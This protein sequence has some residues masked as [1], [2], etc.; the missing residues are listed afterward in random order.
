M[1]KLFKVY[2]PFTVNEIKVNLA[3]PA[4]FYLFILCTMFG[5]FINY[6]LW[7]AIYG[8]ASGATLGGLTRGEM[9]VYVFMSYVTSSLTMIS[10]SENVSEDVVKG[11]VSMN[12]I[13]PIDYRLSL[14]FMA[15][16]NVIYRFFAPCILVWVGLEYYKVVFLG[17]E[18]TSIYN[19]VLYIISLIFSFTLYVLFDFCFGMIAFFT[20]YIF[21]M[22]MAKE[23]LLRFLTGQLI[24]LTFFP[25]IVQRIFDFM[26]FSSMVYTP[27]MIYLGKYSGNEL[28]FVLAR[29][30]VWILIHDILGRII[31]KK[32]TKRLVVLG[33]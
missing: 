27:V 5:S 8:S 21:G 14:I 7:M 26:P 22:A 24:P 29:Q 16:G 3:Y 4:S 13:K 2:I 32:V 6:F 18:I 20:T 23:A 10:I 25:E 31:W 12:L 15:F 28:M 30:L 19:I 11:T 1:K 9:V 17:M 33:G